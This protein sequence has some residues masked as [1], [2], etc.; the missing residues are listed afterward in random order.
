LVAERREGVEGLGV[1]LVQ[2]R[3]RCGHE[4]ADAAGRHLHAEARG[5]HLLELMCL[6]EHD[7]VVLG[8]DGSPAG[9][10]RA[11]EMRV[12]HHDV[13][14]RGAV[15]RPLGEA[16]AARRAVKGA[17]ALT[18]ADAQHVPGPIARFEGEVRPVAAVRGLR[19]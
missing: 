1:A 4:G 14:S 10:M 15:A 2:Q 13:G 18:G 12:H 11:I 7:D 9:E 5:H 6:V 19:P 16:L 3:A 8:Q 17:R